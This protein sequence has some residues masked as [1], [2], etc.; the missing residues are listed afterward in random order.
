MLEKGTFGYINKQKKRKIIGIVLYLLLAVAI[1]LVGLFL[2]KMEQANI[3]TVFAILCVLPWAKQVVALVVFF[4]Y[5]SVSK[6]RYEKVQAQV[7]CGED[8]K[9]Y[10][11]L[12]ITSQDK[13]MHL[14][15]LFVGKGH[16]VALVGKKGQDVAYIR[17]YLS[18]GVKQWADFTVKVVESE[19]VFLAEA[20]KEKVTPKDRGTKGGNMTAEKQGKT[21]TVED[22]DKVDSYLRSLMV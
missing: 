3:F 20:G 15:F 19:K 10:T 2:N 16:V 7:T 5:H 11:D 14:D 12:V 21:F 18:D 22:M 8:E 4:P 13:I 17:K 1:Y 9:L 6:E